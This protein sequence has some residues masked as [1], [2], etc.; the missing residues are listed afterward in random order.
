MVSIVLLLWGGWD[1][2]QNA[3]WLYVSATT[4]ILTSCTLKLVE[5]EQYSYVSINIWK[6]Y[7]TGYTNWGTKI[8]QGGKENKESETDATHV[9]KMM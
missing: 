7:S 6:I 4:R 2:Q 3:L 8:E 1:L 9:K 5:Y